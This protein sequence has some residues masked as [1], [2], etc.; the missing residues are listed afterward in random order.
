MDNGFVM[1]AQRE[2]GELEAKLRQIPE[3]VRWERVKS[4]LDAYQGDAAALPK[5]VVS[6]QRSSTATGHPSTQK[7][8]INQV[9]TAAL[10]KHGVLHRKELLAALEKEGLMANR[11][12]PMQALAIFLSGSEGRFKSVGNGQWELG[13]GSE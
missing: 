12:D 13:A 4:A 6:S 5:P 10:K 8:R 2:L 11:S 1:A 9:L 3:F 7:E